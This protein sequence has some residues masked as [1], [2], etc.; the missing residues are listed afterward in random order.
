MKV[1]REA[2]GRVMRD[3]SLMHMHRSFGFAG[4]AA[5]EMKQSEILGIGRRNLE[6]AV[7]LG[8][9][10]LKVEGVGNRADLVRGADQQYVLES[11][12]RSVA[13]QPPCVCRAS[14]VVTSTRPSP[15]PIRWRIGSGPKAE[16]SGQKTLPFFSVPN[17]LM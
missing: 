17:A 12:Q 6:I 4:G 11:G 13:A 15:I 16:K 8:H 1:E 7:R 14:T 10:L 3:D 9:Q 2:A 5:G